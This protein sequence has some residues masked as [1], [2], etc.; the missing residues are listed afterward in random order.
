MRPLVGG[1]GSVEDMASVSPRHRV[2]RPWEAV[3]DGICKVGVVQQAFFTRIEV[4][5]DAIEV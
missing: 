4:H 1:P 5:D 3:T 2:R